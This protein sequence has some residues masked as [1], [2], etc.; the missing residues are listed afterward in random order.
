MKIEDQ[1][2]KFGSGL[3]SNSTILCQTIVKQF[4]KMYSKTN[5]PTKIGQNIHKII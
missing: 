1:N 4:K 3:K 2:E 5:Q